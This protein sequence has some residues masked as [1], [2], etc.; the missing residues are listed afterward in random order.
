M[1]AETVGNCLSDMG[2]NE[3]STRQFHAGAA[4]QVAAKGYRSDLPSPA[5]HRRIH[6]DALLERSGRHPNRM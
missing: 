5:S 6:G 1:A 3:S 4:E 2:N